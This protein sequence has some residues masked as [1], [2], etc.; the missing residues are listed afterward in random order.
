MTGSKAPPAFPAPYACIPS[1]VLRLLLWSSPP[2]RCCFKGTGCVC[3]APGRTLGS[4]PGTA[5]AGAGGC[6]FSLTSKSPVG[7]SVGRSSFLVP[8][9]AEEEAVSAAVM[10][11][12]RR[13]VKR[14]RASVVTPRSDARAAHQTTRSGHAHVI[15][16]GAR[17][18][19]LTRLAQGVTRFSVCLEGFFSF[20]D[21]RKTS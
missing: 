13:R 5:G 21:K 3:G 15:G 12:K 6:C 20:K 14:E 7:R 4:A 16:E 9:R 18:F 1:M 19:L 8:S 17:A 11:M 10:L 2:P